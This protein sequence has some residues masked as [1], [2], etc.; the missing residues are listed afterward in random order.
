LTSQASEAKDD[1]PRAGL[2][3]RLAALLYDMFLV[4]AIWMLLGLVLQ[5]IFGTESNQVIDGQ[6]VTDP[7][8]NNLLFIL[9]L[10]SSFS[11]YC[12]F[13]TRS[14]QT[15]GMLAWRLRTDSLAGGRLNLQQALIRFAVAWPG[16][17]MLGAG[18]L[19]MYLD[20]QGD[21]VH[22]KLSKSKVVVVPKSYRPF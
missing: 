21:T 18:F 6:V 22:D 19:W 16:F 7:L 3:R 17:L 14:G 8:V 2:L 15:L 20:D 9:M 4:A 5:L 12:W 1:F 11:F 13:W 10:A